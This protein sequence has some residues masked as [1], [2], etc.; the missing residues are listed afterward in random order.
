MEEILFFLNDGHGPVHAIIQTNSN[1][2]GVV[3]TNFYSN[4]EK[5]SATSMRDFDA[6]DLDK[7]PG[8]AS[9]CS[10]TKKEIRDNEHFWSEIQ[11]IVSSTN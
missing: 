3:L 1:V 10:M 7:F 6:A 11:L 4:K 9:N 2:E 8:G 5:K